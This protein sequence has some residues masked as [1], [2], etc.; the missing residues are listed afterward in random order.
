[1][2]Q[3]PRIP[4]WLRWEQSVIYFVTLCVD[5]R[6][7]VLANAEAFAAFKHAADRLRDW[8][9]LAAVLMPD[10]LHLLVTPTEDREARL[11]NFS[12]AI[13]RWMRRELNAS[14]KWQKGSFDRL[15]RSDE[16]L[17]EK[18]LYVEENPVRAGLV[19]DF[20]D[21]PFRYAFNEL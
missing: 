11:G 14:W 8:E 17:T 5:G 1:M 15:L 7:P 16:S 10:H 20:R 6:K 13:K 9:V 21:W 2:G 4:V 3:P 19:K 18:W 12:A